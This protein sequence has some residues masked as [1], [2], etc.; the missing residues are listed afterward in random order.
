MKIKL[1]LFFL[2][3]ALGLQAQKTLPNLILKDLNGNSLDLNAASEKQAIIVSFWATWCVPCLKELEV[4]NH[5][6]SF[7]EEELR[8]TVLAVSIDDSRTVSRIIPMINGN[9]WSFEVFT[10]TNQEIKRSLNI[11]DIPHTLLVYQNKIVYE[12]TGYI[13]GDEEILFNKIKELNRK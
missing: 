4:L 12:S 7:L 11:I 10:D 13:T 6:L 1:F 2:L 8:T 3:L 9:S 5:N